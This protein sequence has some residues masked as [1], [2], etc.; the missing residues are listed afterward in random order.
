[1]NSVK[2]P[3]CEAAFS[4]SASYCRECGSS[5]PEA[6]AA[7]RT[8]WNQQTVDSGRMM[9]MVTHLLALVTWLI[10]PLVVLF[11]SDNDFVVQNAKNAVMWQ[12]MLVIYS[13][14]AGILV[15][16]GI[17]ILLLMAL[18]LL[19]LVFIVIATVKANDGVAWQY[20]LTPAV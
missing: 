12:L 11:V 15:F 13:I 16:I 7:P 6:P 2:C 19:N 17:G 4:A 10:G 14:L 18:W 9:A 3:E 8:K 20:P 5:L 1:M